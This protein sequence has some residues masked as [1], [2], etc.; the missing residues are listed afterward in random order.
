MVDV[1][2]ASGTPPI[3]GADGYISMSAHYSTA[4][5]TVEEDENDIDMRIVQ[6]FINVS[7]GD[8]IGRI[9]PPEPGTPGRNIMGLPIPSRPGKPLSLTFGKNIRTDGD[10]SLLI[11]SATGRFCQTAGEISV[12]EEYIVKGDVNFRI[13]HINF[14]GV[15]EV[16]GDVLDNFD[17]TASKGLTVSGN[18]GVCKIVSDG[19]ITFCGMDGQEKGTIVCGGTIRANFI[20]DADIVCA[21]DVIVGVE[22]HNCTIRTLG[23][24]IVDK[25]GISGGSCIA[26]GGMEAKK[27]GSPSSQHTILHSGVD[28]RDVDELERLFTVLNEIQSKI[29]KSQ[30]LPEI[31]ELRKTSAEMTDQIIAI[32]GAVHATANAKINVKAVLFE[33]VQITLGSSTE[34]NIEQKDGPHSII[35]NTFEGGFRFLS[36]TGL[37]VKAAD[38]ELA[39][40]RERKM[41][42]RQSVS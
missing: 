27:I 41:A 28:Y 14:K 20:H 40:E 18:I 32:R 10:G 30:S 17:I 3:P 16:R 35:E 25:G 5:H 13:G 9:I 8:E 6:T 24:I 12:E 2:L 4:I 38:I 22:V 1:L 26:L 11:A 7:S 36:M 21:G 15:V 34:T 42:S 39:F 29:S 19:D 23:R 33:N 31:A 37:N